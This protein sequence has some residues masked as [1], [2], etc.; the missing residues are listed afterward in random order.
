LNTFRALLL[1]LA[2]FC[3]PYVSVAGDALTL[4][5]HP[6]LPAT[7]LAGRFTPLADYLARITGRP[8]EIR[9]AKDYQEHIDRVGRDEVDIAYMGPA[10]YVKLVDAYGEKPILARL[11][12]NGKPSF[13]GVIVTTR[14]SPIQSLSELAG[15]R[16]AFG[17]PDSTMSH[18]V[19]RYMLAEAGVGVERLGGYEYLHSHVNVAL[20]VLM[21]HFDA[22]AVKEEVF[23]EYEKRGLRALAWSPRISEHLFVTSK[24]LPPETVKTLREAL[25]SLRDTEEG[26]AILSS[27]K[28]GVTAMVPASDGDYDT[29]R[30]I[31]RALE[32]QGV[33]P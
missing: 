13:Q 27:I 17:D 14:E 15:K 33:T 3:F 2:V 30:A 16:F 23:Y 26:R 22:G 31:L 32:E 10:P 7:E 1:F 28:E 20:G 18:L 12:I 8:V 21:G 19:P 24:T 11:E 25:F 29:L 9:I 4:G 6:Y 5:I